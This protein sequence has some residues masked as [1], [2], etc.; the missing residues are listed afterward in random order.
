M[1]NNIPVHLQSSVVE[2]WVKVQAWHIHGPQNAAEFCY[3]QCLLVLY[4]MKSRKLLEYY[5]L[6]ESLLKQKPISYFQGNSGMGTKG[7]NAKCEF[8]Q[9]WVY[10]ILLFGVQ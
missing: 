1:L 4:K 3:F 9:N 10:Q 2:K 8:C 5:T 6:K 7:P